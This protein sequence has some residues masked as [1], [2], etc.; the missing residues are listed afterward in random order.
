MT[1]CQI[2]WSKYF[3]YDESTGKLA[4]VISPSSRIPA[5]SSP[6]YVNNDGYLAVGLGR[7][8]HLVHRI[9]WLLLNPGQTIEEGFQ[10]DHIDHNRLNNRPANL[11][12][13]R[14]I[15]NHRNKSKDRRNSSG[16]TG[17]GWHSY[18][19]KWQAKISVLG[20]RVYLGLFDSKDEAIAARKEAEIK[21]GFHENHGK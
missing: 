2:D 21:Y 20:R 18:H 10:I 14:R 8:K 19:E 1:T 11:R 16:V 13:V 15:E 17:V 5:G 6:T 4:W 12:K 7:R 3:T 9:V